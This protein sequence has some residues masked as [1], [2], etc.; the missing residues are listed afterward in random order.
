MH[1]YWSPTQMLPTTSN[2]YFIYLYVF[3]LRLTPP[4]YSYGPPHSQ[5]LHVVI[6]FICYRVKVHGCWNSMLLLLMCSEELEK[7]TEGL[8]KE[9]NK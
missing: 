3:P 7:S 1:S 4:L 5:L 6:N 9:K 2:T 8:L